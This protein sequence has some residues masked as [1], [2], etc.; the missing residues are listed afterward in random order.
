[1][2]ESSQNEKDQGDDLATGI[3]DAIGGN[4][5]TLDQAM[6]LKMIFCLVREYDMI[7]CLSPYIVLYMMVVK[8]FQL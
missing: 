8:N 7:C 6:I 5:L 4:F 3:H 1:M 2:Q